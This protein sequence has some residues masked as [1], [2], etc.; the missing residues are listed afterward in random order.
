M[1]RVP[2][3]RDKLH[4]I[5]MKVNNFNEMK[6]IVSILIIAVLFS[7]CHTSN[8]PKTE[9]T[10]PVIIVSILPQKTFIEKIAGNDFDIIV[11]IP[12][13][14][15]PEAY[16]LIPSQ[17]KDIAR[18]AAWLR[19]GNIG[20]ELS[21]M[22]KIAQVNKNMKIYD[23]SEGL[24]LIA[25][26][27]TQSGGQVHS[28]GVDPHTWM[29]PAL[30][31]KMAKRIRDILSEINPEGSQKY[32]KGYL[33]FITEIDQLNVDIKKILQ[34]FEGKTIIMFHPSLT[35]FAR[36]YKLNQ[37]SLE[38]GGKEPTPHH[39]KQVVDLA[40]KEKI[41][42]IYIQSEFDKEHAR[43][44]AEEISGK[45]IQFSPLNPDWINNLID[46]ATTVRDNF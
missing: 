36:D 21:W 13:G 29:S 22:D 19:I 9:E 10:K 4:R 37:V 24:D 33:E 3:C 28:G 11:L 16:S 25:E 26:N 35:Y 46:I 7:S 31:K 14:A 30:V 20:F 39:I 5:P 23:L 43:I 8:K 1:K 45:I 12:P 40:N 41:K 6:F 17:L 38:S 18:S 42:V 32:M 44:F 2:I 15:S 27:S 34:G